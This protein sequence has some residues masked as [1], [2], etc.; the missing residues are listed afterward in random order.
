MFRKITSEFDSV[1]SAERAAKAIKDNISDIHDITITAK[2]ISHKNNNDINAYN[3]PAYAPLGSYLPYN[4][5]FIGSQSIAA[6][7]F[8]NEIRNSTD[9]SQ[10]EHQNSYDV[11]LEISCSNDVVHSVSSMLISYGGL[12]ITE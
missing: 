3:F 9:Y 12:K 7:A 8:Y 5:N 6:Y 1:D 2:T 11:I 10:S 4:V